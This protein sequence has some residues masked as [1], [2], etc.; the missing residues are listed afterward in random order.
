MV[1]RLSKTGSYF[2][3]TV[4]IVTLILGL[5]LVPI[6][7]AAFPGGNGKIA[8]TRFDGN[9]Y[10]IFVIN[11][12]GSDVTPLTDN[13]ADDS[14]PAWSADGSKITFVSRRDGEPEIFTMNSDGT[15]QK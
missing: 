10:E 1:N 8:F 12:D 13:D 11:P 2:I 4:L 15:N 6:T 3:V 14:A 5:E 9:D 7:F